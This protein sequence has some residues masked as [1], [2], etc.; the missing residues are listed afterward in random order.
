[1]DKEKAIQD[2]ESILERIQELQR[3]YVGVDIERA[4]EITMEEY[5]SKGYDKALRIRDVKDIHL[6]KQ[7]H[8]APD[9]DDLVAI[10]KIIETII[11]LIK[12]EKPESSKIEKLLSKIAPWGAWANAIINALQHNGI[13]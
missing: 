6:G 1:M 5:R 8:E 7:E 2:L 4:G 10:A 9:K 12:E 3:E 13:L 11:L